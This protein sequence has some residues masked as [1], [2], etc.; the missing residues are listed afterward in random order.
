VGIAVLALY[1]VLGGLVPRGDLTRKRRRRRRRVGVRVLRFELFRLVLIYIG[2]H[3]SFAL[4]FFGNLLT[5]LYVEHHSLAFRC[6]IY[7]VNPN[8]S[9][10]PDIVIGGH[11]KP[12][13]SHTCLAGARLFDTVR[14]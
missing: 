1:G 2:S 13:I 3:E 12:E 7:P 11:L 4:I 10:R 5:K 6:Y 14:P 8:H 9:F